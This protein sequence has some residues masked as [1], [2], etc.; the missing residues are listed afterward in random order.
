VR[1]YERHART[2]C[3]RAPRYHSATAAAAATGTRHL[4]ILYTMIPLQHR[5]VAALERSRS[6]SPTDLAFSVPDCNRQRY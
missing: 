4:R 3:A 6:T 5:G 1:A 2:V